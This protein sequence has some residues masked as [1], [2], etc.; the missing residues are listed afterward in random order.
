MLFVFSRDP[1][2]TPAVRSSPA[3]LRGGYKTG[4]LYPGNSCATEQLR[5][6]VRLIALAILPRPRQL[7]RDGRVAEGARLESVYTG[8][9]IVGSNPTP[10]AIFVSNFN[11]LWGDACRLTHGGCSAL[12]AAVLIKRRDL[13]IREINPTRSIAVVHRGQPSSATRVRSLARCSAQ[14]ACLLGGRESI[15]LVTRRN[16]ARKRRKADDKRA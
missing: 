4:Q 3:C 8:N 9:R 14:R 6:L 13:G 16:S 2:A 5:R 7:R 12:T 10:S 1:V 15:G 11:W